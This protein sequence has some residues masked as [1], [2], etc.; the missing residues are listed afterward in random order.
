[1]KQWTERIHPN[2]WPGLLVRIK[3]SRSQLRLAQ[4]AGRVGVWDWWP[5]TRAIVFSD[6]MN[7]LYGLPPGTVETYEDWLSRIHPDDKPAML[8]KRD[9]ALSER[10]PFDLEFRILHASGRIRW[11]VARGNGVYDEAGRLTRVIGINIDITD[12]K[13]VEELL[14][15]E[16]EFSTDVIHGT[17]AIICGIAPDGTT[18]F[19]NPA[20][21]AITG[22]RPEELVGKNWWQLFYPGAEYKQVEQLFSDLENEEVRDYEMTLTTRDG[23]KR[24]VSWN[25]LLTRDSY[26]KVILTIGFGNDVTERKRAELAL[27][28]IYRQIQDIID[29]TTALV[30]SFDLEHRFILANTAVAELRNSTLEQ[31][32]GKRRHEFMPKEDADW[33]EANDRKVIEAGRAIQFE[34]H[35]ELPGRSIPWLTTQFPLRDEQGRI[36][37]TAGI[38]ADIS[39]RKQA[40]EAL[41]ASEAK[42]QAALASIPDALSISDTEGRLVSFNDAFVKYHRFR[43]RDECSR[44]IADGPIYLDVYTADGHPGSP[45]M[46]ALPRALRGETVNNTRYTLRRKDTGETWIGSY[47]F[48]P[49]RDKDGLIIGAVVVARDITEQQQMQDELQKSRDQLDLRVKERTAA[50]EA[51]NAK[52]RLVPSLLIQAQEEE[53]QRLASELHDSIGQT[54]AALKYRIEHISNKLGERAIDEAIQLLNG[55]IP[56]LQH[57]IDETR[58]IYM[59][60]KPIILSD[61]GIL[62]ALEWYRRELVSIYPKVHIE[63]KSEIGEDDI[64]EKIKTAIFRITQEALNNCCK[65]SRAEWVDVRLAGNNGAIELE[66]SDEGIGMDL[67]NIMQSLSARSLGLI[68]MRERTELTGGEFTI[69]SAPDEGTTVRVSWP[70]GKSA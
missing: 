25:S 7:V 15:E 41:R 53:K 27:A 31:M 61:H 17:P 23:G 11:M 3:E 56:V 60:L 12:R 18:T 22:Y 68:G 45:E 37:A 20:G 29:H 34:E 16:K 35:S 1:M 48:G 36:Y 6:Q 52:L 64:S 10:E 65:H 19:I 39:E 4:E 9:K 26:G 32:I 43:N 49:V 54:L 67:D 42:L 33:H 50:L 47:S 70:T 66:I 55:F 5:Q 51:A 21:E 69:K 14:R 57:S 46:R 63:L 44:S 8:A 38:S 58:T 30:Y 2:D 59:G 24:I 28:A 13:R 62:A 40:E